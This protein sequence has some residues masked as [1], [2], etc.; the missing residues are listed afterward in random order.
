M[1]AELDAHNERMLTSLGKPDITDLKANL[2]EKES[3]A[4]HRETTK[5]HAAVE[6]GRAPNKRNRD[7]KLSENVAKSRR[8]GPG[9]LCTPKEIGYR[10]HHDP[11]KV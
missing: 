5:E 6:T 3:G 11:G 2:K 7:R 8:N 10:R 9:K 4:E 1:M